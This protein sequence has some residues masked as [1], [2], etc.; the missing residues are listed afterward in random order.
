M[1]LWYIGYYN[2]V[3]PFFPSVRKYV[4]AVNAALAARGVGTSVVKR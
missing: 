3:K 4:A 2:L 1:P